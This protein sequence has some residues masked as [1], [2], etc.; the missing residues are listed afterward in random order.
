MPP[1]KA[2]GEGA[3]TGS[4]VDVVL[5]YVDLCHGGCSDLRLFV[6]DLEK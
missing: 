6:T 1:S 4:D 5:I 3:H 2:D